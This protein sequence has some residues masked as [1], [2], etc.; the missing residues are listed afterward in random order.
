MTG[1]TVGYDGS[2]SSQQALE[3]AMREAAIRHAPLTV[4]TVHP[5]AASGWT[6]HPILLPED[7]P[8]VEEARQ[9]AMDAIGKAA[10]ELGE[11]DT[12][13][14]TVRAVSGIPA[15]EL[16]SASAGADLLVVGARGHSGISHR[17]LGSVSLAMLQHA[18]CPVAVIRPVGSAGP[19]HHAQPGSWIVG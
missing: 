6:G 16:M 8:A 11:T 7:H 5:V 14:V 2:H 15:R 3:W 13:P 18:H 19:S 12:I 4:L 10:A 17:L 1:I 9:A